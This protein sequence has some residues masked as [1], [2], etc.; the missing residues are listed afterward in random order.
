MPPQALS[1]KSSCQKGS[2]ASGRVQGVLEYG[3]ATQGYATGLDRVPYDN[4]PALLHEGER[5]LTAGQARSMDAAGGSP[6]VQIVLNGV[7]IREDADIDR[8]A[9]VFLERMKLARLGGALS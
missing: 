3:M 6:P 5:V 1:S 7:T 2:T 4:F 8:L 9:E